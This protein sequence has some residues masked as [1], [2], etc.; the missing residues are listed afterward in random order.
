VRSFVNLYETHEG[1]THV[2]GLRRGLG[3]LVARG[4]PRREK[5]LE[6]LRA[7]LVGIIS[8]HHHEPSFDSPTR[9]QL[10]SPEV[11]PIVEGVVRRC[12]REFAD[13]QPD[14]VK[15]LLASCDPLGA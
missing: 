12:L 8:V 14:E 10:H 6:E 4:A 1:G 5:I 9:S 2:A 15:E 7:R 3:A 13:Q 11:R